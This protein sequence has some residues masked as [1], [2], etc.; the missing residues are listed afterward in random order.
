MK[1]DQIAAQLYTVRDLCQTPQSTAT[2]LRKISDIGFRSIEVAGIC[3]LDAKDLR[4]IAEDCGLVICAFHGDM[5][6]TLQ[7]SEKIVEYL[8]A[9]NCQYGV[10]SYPLGFDIENPADVTRLINQLTKAK[11]IFDQGSKTLCYHHHA[12]EFFRHDGS[13]ILEKILRSTDLQLELDTYWVQHGGGDI[14][15]WCKSLPDRVSVIHLKDY[16]IHQSQPTMKEVGS[17]NL[18]WERIIPAAKVAGCKWFVVEQDTCPGDPLNSLRQS[19]EYLQ[20]LVAN[21]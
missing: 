11:R 14:L 17:G 18:Q 10:Y 19:F 15:E 2:T 8:D 7:S 6:T 20:P 4:A 9:I 1:I 3:P 13:T 21:G 16:G 12:L 5:N